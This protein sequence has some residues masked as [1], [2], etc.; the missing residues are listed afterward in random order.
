VVLFNQKTQRRQI[1]DVLGRIP[2]VDPCWFRVIRVP[3]VHDPSAAPAVVIPQDR[4]QPE[5]GSH[6]SHG[7]NTDKPIRAPRA[8]AT[9]RRF[10][11]V[12]FNQ[13]TQRRQISDVLGRTPGADPCWFGVIRVPAV[14]D[15][16]AAPAVVN[17]QD[18][19]QPEH[20]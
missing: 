18:R 14:H 2:G 15:P 6:G 12:L 8:I 11:V 7:T 5:H 17:P 16:S 9:R 1:S 10:A 20:G 19:Q 4:Q 3:A 13:K